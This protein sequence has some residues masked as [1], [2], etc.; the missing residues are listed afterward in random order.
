MYVTPTSMYQ[1]AEKVV[2][3]CTH[4]S[5]HTCCSEWSELPLHITHDGSA[6]PNSSYNYQGEQS[7]VKKVSGSWD[8]MYEISRWFL[9]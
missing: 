8:C 3:E 1:N 4:E 7:S 9:H 2:W 5:T 6:L